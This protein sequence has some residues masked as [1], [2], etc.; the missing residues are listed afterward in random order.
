MLLVLLPFVHAIPRGNAKLQLVKIEILVSF[1]SLT[2]RAPPSLPCS[3][4]GVKSLP[5]LAFP[6]SPA[7]TT[8]LVPALFLQFV[9][10]YPFIL[11][12]LLLW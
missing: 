8:Y 2:G 1:H 3:H 6:G 10:W 4:T 5:K 9:Q 7:S 12:S 11:A